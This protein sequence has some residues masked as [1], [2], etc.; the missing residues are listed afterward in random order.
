[1]KNTEILNWLN[2]VLETPLPKKISDH[3]LINIGDKSHA[4]SDMYNAL[5]E[6]SK[7]GRKRG[8]IGVSDIAN[9]VNKAN[10]AIKKAELK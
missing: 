8:N 7:L 6:V 9:I 5:K 1:M 10:T 3:L 4:S 2:S